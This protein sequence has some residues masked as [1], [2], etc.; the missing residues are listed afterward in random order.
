MGSNNYYAQGVVV[1]VPG[2]GDP[3]I[4]TIPSYITYTGEVNCVSTTNYLRVAAGGSPAQAFSAVE[5]Y[6]YYDPRAARTS[7]KDFY[8][9]VSEWPK[10]T[11][12]NAVAIALE[13]SYNCSGDR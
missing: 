4:V 13:L 1:V 11:D 10:A 7:P 9:Q 3:F 12:T 2:G 6:Y 8:T 5:V